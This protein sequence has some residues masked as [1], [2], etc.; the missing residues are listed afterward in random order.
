MIEIISVLSQLLFILAIILAFIAFFRTG[1]LKHEI[2]R[3]ESVI[4]QLRDSQAQILARLEGRDPEH[5][6]DDI[7]QGAGPSAGEAKDAAQTRQSTADAEP[8]EE[9]PE[10][11]V[12]P[13]TASGGT[14]DAGSVPFIPPGWVDPASEAVRSAQ[15][16]QDARSLEQTVGTRWIVWLGAATLGLGAIFLVKHSIDQ[17][18][19]T[20]AIRI[21]SGAVGAFALMLAGEYMRRG[22]IRRDIAGMSGAHIP[23]ALTA[24]G[25]VA[26]FATI[27]AAYALYH[28]LDPLL[29]FILLAAVSFAALASSM[30]HGPG[31]AAMGLVGSYVTPALVSTSHPR[32][33]PLFI[34]L[35]FVTAASF[36]TAQARSWL[37]LAVS[38]LGASVIWGGIWFAS[39]WQSGDGFAMGF[40]IAGLLG[41]T[42]VL[43]KQEEP[44][45]DSDHPAGLSLYS[46]WL[47]ADRAASF[48]LGAIGLL[49]V[50]LLRQDNYSTLSWFV[51]AAVIGLF[52]TSGWVWRS[53]A[54]L[55][56]LGAA[57]FG[58]AY[59]TWHFTQIVDFVRSTELVEPPELSEFLTFGT[60]FAGA[61]ALTGFFAVLRRAGN[62]LWALVAAAT[63]LATFA[64]AYWR[65]TDFEHSIPFGLV[66][67]ALA[68]IATL[69]AD[70]VDRA[71]QTRRYEVSAGLFA[72]AGVIALALA[73]TILLEKGWLTIALAAITPA[74][75]YIARQRSMPV[76]RWLGAGIALLVAARLVYDPLIVG[77]AL[78]TTPIF[79]WLLYGYGLPAFAF[80]LAASIFRKQRDDVVPALLEAAAILF[81][82]ALFFLEIRHYMN[83]G[84]IFVRQFSLAEVSLHSMV[85]LSLSLGYQW[86][87]ERTRRWIPDI[88]A[89]GFGVVGIVS[90]L[91]GHL[92]RYN[93]LLTDHP[94]GSG[95]IFNDLLLG[96]G[97]PAILCGV[98]Y[99]RASG[100]RPWLFV[101]T[102][103]LAAFIL[104]FAWLS[105][106]LRAYFQGERLAI[107]LHPTSDAE[108]YSYSALWLVYGLGLLGAAIFLRKQVLRHA[109]M[110]LVGLTIIKVFVFDMSQLTGFLRA[111]SFIGLGLALVG[112]GWLYQRMIFPQDRPEQQEQETAKG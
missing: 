44:G 83:G 37:W 31:L 89:T 94:I 88:A 28:F 40:Y 63:P 5:G 78:G 3:L 60:M 2:G 10:K 1:R 102:A 24:A 65:A 11:P 109:A 99:W 87:S 91:A 97:L 48:G 107:H 51:F 4:A 84:S 92:L 98:L 68:G 86:L 100:N 110:A 58:L 93:P 70:R 22:E 38:A 96:Y 45:D 62:P 82:A 6:T 17:G 71:G 95:F 49:A 75:A 20:P 39:A 57:L 79:N 103:G 42:L 73:M 61:F 80:A 66:G 64:Y 30:L 85:W 47:V 35:L 50:A 67:I 14:G 18:Y 52:L 33:W 36:F 104:A 23:G 59:G 41:L 72:T 27:Y 81:T 69:A 111:L 43:L 21:L 34:Y 15:A 29:A 19:L 76:L 12:G 32:A 55:C 16:S 56:V 46:S 108:R 25:I 77:T 8:E 9:S 106:E 101:K 105:L 7:K 112:I 90:V 74:L 53:L 54:L 13:A 26:A